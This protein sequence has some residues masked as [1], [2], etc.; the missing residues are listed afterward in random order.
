MF[1]INIVNKKINNARMLPLEF[2][3]NIKSIEDKIKEYEINF[4]ILIFVN[5]KKEYII[6]IPNNNKV[7][8]SFGFRAID[9]GIL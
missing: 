6:G 9:I 7:P 3:K 1:N 4:I 8:K 2:V 5:D